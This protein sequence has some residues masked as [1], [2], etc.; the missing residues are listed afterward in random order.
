MGTAMRTIWQRTRALLLAM[1]VAIGGMTGWL[2]PGGSYAYA[3]AAEWHPV[4][5]AGL[6]S[7]ASFTSLYVYNGT[8]YVAYTDSVILSKATV[9]KYNGSSWETVGIE[10]FSA[11]AS[12]TS[13][14]VYGGTPYVAYQDWGNRGKATMKKYNGSSWET[15]GIEGF[16][17]SDAS[18]TSLY[19]YGGTPYV[20]YQDWGNSGKA[21]VKKYNGSS[22]ETVGS[23]GFS[24]GQAKNT[25]LYVSNGT[26]Y[27]AYQDG[28]NSQKATVKK[29]NGSSWETVGIEG[30][31]AGQADFM[32]LSVDNGIPYVAYKDYGNSYKATVMKYNGSG[33]ETVGNAG[34][35]AY[36]A[37]QMSLYIEG[38]TPYVAYSDW[39]KAGK[40][41]VKKYNE[42]SWET[43]GIEGFT[44]G[45]G[46][47]ISLYVANGTPYV[48]YSDYGNGYKATVMKYS[49]IANGLTVTTGD[50]PGADKNGKTKVS[51][52]ETVG[53]D[54]TFKYKNLKSAAVGVPDE[55]DSIGADYVDL[56]SDG[57]IA[58]ANGDKIAVAEVDSSGKVVKFGQSAV[59]LNTVT[60]NGNGASVGT[61]PTDSNTYQKG[62]AATVL[63]NPGNLAKP[64]FTFAGWNT[65]ADGNGTTYIAG[66]TLNMGTTAVTLYVKWA[67]GLTVTTG[68]PPGADK[69]GKTKVSVAETI[70][71][72]NTFKYKNF[73]SAEVTV[74]SVGDS[75]GAD[76][77]ELSPEGIIEVANG[78]KIAVVEVDASEKVVKFGQAS[79]A[80]NTVTYNGNGATAGT[81]PTDSNTYQKGATVT[82]SNPGNLAK[83][84]FL[85]A[86][87][88][89]QADGNGTTYAAGSTLS[90]GTTAVTLYANW[91]AGL[92][93]TTGDP[94]VAD[95]DGKT[96]VSVA[97]TIGNGNKLK[98]KNFTGAEVT[99]PN[100]G[101]SI[102]TDYAD[103]PTEGL[104]AAVNGDKIAVAEVDASGKV[105][106]FGQA[107]VAVNTITYNGNGATAGSAPTDSKAYQKGA[108]VTVLANPGNLAKSG[109]LFVGWNTQADGNGTTYAAGSTLSMGTTAV[110]LYAKWKAGL[111]VTTGD[112]AGADKDGKTQVSV[113]ETVGVGNTIKY[114]NFASADLTVPSVGD[115]IGADYVNLPSDGIIE[116][117]NGDKIAVAEVDASG[118]V[119][120]FGQATVALNS[121]TYNG[122]GATAGT[123]PTDTNTY[124]KG[125]AVTVLANPGNLTKSG[126]LFT[127]W[128]TQEDGNGTTYAT[129]STLSMGTTAVTL[130]AKWTAGLT[131]TTG[132]PAV[133]D[134]DGKTQVSVVETIGNGN[135]LKYKNFTSA[136]VTVPSVGESI[137]TDYADLPTDGLIP[138]DNGDK[139]AVAEVDASGKVVNFGQAT[140][141]LNTIT[142]NGNGATAGTAP[143]DSN[144]Y[145]KGAAVT[146]LANPGNLT[147]PGFQFTG[148]NTQADGKGTTYA[149]GSTLSMGTTAVTLYAKWTTGLTVTTRGAVG[150]GMDGKTKMSIKET[151]GNGNKLKYK[152]FKNAE[153]TVPSEGDRIGTDY[154]DLPTDGIIEAANGDKIAVIEV[155]A[156]GKTVR[157]AQT[158][159]KLAASGLTVTTSDP[160]GADKNGKTIVSVTDTIGNGN[161][162]KYKNYKSAAVT[163]PSV[164]DSIGADYTELPTEGLIAA[165]NGDKIAM[166]EVDASG[167]VVKFGQAA[168]TVVNEAPPVTGDA[169]GDGMITATDMLLLQKY[170]KDPVKFSLT[171]EQKKA[172][173]MNGD[174]KLDNE[175]V[176]LILAIAV[177][178]GKS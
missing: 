42:S 172:L 176:K 136:E 15:V 46:R 28:A 88:N 45:E 25:T 38:G 75:I 107:T 60:Y 74:P 162:L 35:S 127:G 113:A 14:Y 50:P 156:D 106:N 40:V 92:T 161:K 137:G 71:S 159:A 126:F 8:P 52:A 53:A 51:V 83:P 79:V 22:W 98:Y 34:F 168:A 19:V 24:A 140:V 150:A 26:P 49:V 142:Y 84:G 123:V 7:N 80:L 68:D 31:S 146:V 87:W 29:Y 157:F 81:A 90:M 16:S 70:G 95:K 149:A 135:K 61:V 151:I 41:T 143:T 76:Y 166:V 94:A 118:K 64:G 18:Y 104:I 67:P 55:G 128:N 160:A 9:K 20:A 6:G 32:S 37:D 96:Q 174:N 97:E 102:G 124:Q 111:T 27:V 44:T 3:A 158:T 33:W 99:V 122:N 148:W 101:D 134:K 103:L 39:M 117:T 115:S 119:V 141:A 130:Y 73:T 170:L 10:G 56:P 120:N 58:V 121:V 59:A 138:A 154:S 100:V 167:N 30:F 175:D 116:A 12:Y 2:A 69:A 147:K 110:T 23:A 11:S 178:K 114:K 77:A 66:N 82:L 13:L 4:G 132:D 109:F 173:D 63:A 93:V 171:D 43:V 72:G 163:V 36:S 86:G 169:D 165:A 108:A 78:D 155:D 129:G 62:A 145:Q 47:Y 48:A 164:G 131:V 21:T 177:G 105:V 112:P 153:V 57:I 5:Q 54:N 91:M 89:T 85:F 152:N 65:Q 139:I 133:A 125:A 144:T 1:L 17:A